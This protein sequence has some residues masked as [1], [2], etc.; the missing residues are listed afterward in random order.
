MYSYRVLLV[1]RVPAA[2]IAI[3]VAATS[4]AGR[5]RRLDP[6]R[7][8]QPEDGVVRVAAPAAA[9]RHASRGRDER[10]RNR[11]GER[12]ERDGRD[13]PERAGATLRR[14]PCG[15]AA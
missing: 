12:N 9:E 7:P 4:I 14:G 11:G 5:H 15:A 3:A 8:E 2:N 10:E 1:A 13:R 6:P